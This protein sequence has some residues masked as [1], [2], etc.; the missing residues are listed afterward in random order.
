MPDA[1]TDVYRISLR[2]IDL[3]GFLLL[4]H[5]KSQPL[6]FDGK[7]DFLVDNAKVVLNKKNEIIVISTRITVLR[8]EQ[9]DTESGDSQDDVQF[10]KNIDVT[11]P[12]Q[13]L[14]YIV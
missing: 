9:S 14:Q 8:V 5:L 2:D 10:V 7:E 1:V 4:R 13:P 12:N 3:K 11:D 6:N